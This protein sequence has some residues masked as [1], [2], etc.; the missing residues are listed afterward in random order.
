MSAS[1]NESSVDP[2]R[3]DLVRVSKKMVEQL[4]AQD[5]QPVVLIGLERF[6]D[7]TVELTFRT[8]EQGAAG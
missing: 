5:P 4:L 7:G 3:Y 6:E 1:R 8:P 2:T